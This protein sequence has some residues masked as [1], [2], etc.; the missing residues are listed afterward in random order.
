[1]SYK[2]AVASSDGKFINEHF[3]RSKQF[4]IFEVA[5]NNEYRFLELRHNTPPCNSGEH[6]EDQMEKTIN[7]LSDCSI[8]LVSQIGPGA[9]R[10]LQAKGMRSYSVPDFIEDALTKLIQ[11]ESKKAGR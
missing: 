2:I 8:V 3:G 5:E 7:L 9:E 11:S 6:G 4:L 1:M 10:K